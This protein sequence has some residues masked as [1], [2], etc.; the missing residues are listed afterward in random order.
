MVFI[1]VFVKFDPD[2]LVKTGPDIKAKRDWLFGVKENR[3]F[4]ISE[5]K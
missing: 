5:I 4:L 3:R 1:K 2:R